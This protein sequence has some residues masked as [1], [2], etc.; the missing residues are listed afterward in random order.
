MFSTIDFGRLCG[1]LY[2]FILLLLV[3]QFVDLA[4]L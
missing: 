1:F 3:Q 4:L 2:L